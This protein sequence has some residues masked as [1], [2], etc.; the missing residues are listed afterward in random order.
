LD[1]EDDEFM[2]LRMKTRQGW[3]EDDEDLKTNIL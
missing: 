1:G 2:G 3:I